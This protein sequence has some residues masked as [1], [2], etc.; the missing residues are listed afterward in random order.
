MIYRNF[1]VFP[2]F[3]MILTILM[4]NDHFVDFPSFGASVANFMIR[5][6]LRTWGKN[7]TEGN[8]LSP[9]VVPEGE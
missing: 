4:H 7:N 2:Y 9:C 3:F 8:C 5:L 1:S 6:K